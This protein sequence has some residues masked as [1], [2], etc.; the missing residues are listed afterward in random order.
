MYYNKIMQRWKSWKYK[1]TTFLII[2]L[3]FAYSLFQFDMF[4]RTLLN[5]GSLGYI[6]AFLGG[7][8]FVSTFTIASGATILLI[9][10]QNIPAWQIGLIA[11]LGA[12]S[13]DLLIFK[14]VKNKLLFELTAIYNDIGGKHLTKLFKTKYFSWFFPVFGAFIIASPLPDELGVSLLGLSRMKTYKFVLLSFI[15]NATGIFLVVS[16]STVIKP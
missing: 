8:L 12:V 11:G 5:L 3:I 16:V 9:L 13:G 6:G 10:S 4:H 7:I 1:N 2:S 15:L 14:F